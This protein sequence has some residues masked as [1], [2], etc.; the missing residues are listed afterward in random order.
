[1]LCMFLDSDTS[2]SYGNFKYDLPTFFCLARTKKENPLCYPDS[3]FQRSWLSGGPLQEQRRLQHRPWMYKLKS[4]WMKPS[5]RSLDHGGKPLDF[6]VLSAVCY[7]PGG[8]H[9]HTRSGFETRSKKTP[10]SEMENRVA[11]LR[12]GIEGRT[13][14][15]LR[16]G[17][18]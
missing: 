7:M 14:P 8:E 9:Q 5:L 11:G 6:L 12:V 10:Q 2:S 13:S 3:F 1:M 16:L 18:D 17:Q 4:R 15:G